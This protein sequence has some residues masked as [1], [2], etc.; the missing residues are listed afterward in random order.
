MLHITEACVSVLSHF[1]PCLMS[2]QNR[3]WEQVVQCVYQTDCVICISKLTTHFCTLASTPPSLCSP[4]FGEFSWNTHIHHCQGHKQLSISSNP[5]FS[6]NKSFSCS[7]RSCAVI[8]LW[9]I[10]FDLADIAQHAAWQVTYTGGLKSIATLTQIECQL[11]S[12]CGP[13]QCLCMCQVCPPEY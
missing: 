3:E 1:S 9:L 12:S 8:F 7:L 5:L 2:L 6:I 10:K 13:H 11:C 4:G